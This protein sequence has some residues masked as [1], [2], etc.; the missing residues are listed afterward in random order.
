M[1]WVFHYNFFFKDN[2]PIWHSKASHFLS[3]QLSVNKVSKNKEMPL[4]FIIILA[5]PMAY[6]S[7]WARD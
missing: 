7:S 2:Q 6:G 1:L 4:E 3:E 5:L